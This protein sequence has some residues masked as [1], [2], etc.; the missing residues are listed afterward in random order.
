MAKYRFVYANFWSDDRVMDMAAAEKLCFLY[1][2]TNSQ[3]TQIGI[4]SLNIRKAAFDMGIPP[5]KVE[6]YFRRF[7]EN[8]L[9][10]FNRDTGEM[11]V[12][13]WGRYNFTRGGKPVED[14]V[15][16]ELSLVKDASL[17]SFVAAHIPPGRIRSLYDTWTERH[18]KQNGRKEKQNE[19][20]PEKTESRPAA[21]RFFERVFGT[22]APAVEQ[23]LLEWCS[24]LSEEL[25][26]EA[27]K[28]SCEADRP[29]AYAQSILT[30][31]QAE[32][33]STLQ[34]MRPK[35][36][37]AAEVPLYEPLVLDLTAGE[38]IG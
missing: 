7:E 19:T 22:P 26:I 17:V 20:E 33:K 14:C 8:G 23:G 12:R 6:Q 15:E 34:D 10:R 4:Y 32:G 18:Q 29:Y 21:V 2:L 35:P 36:E 1:V 28:L 3:T 13:H 30:S 11:A 25:V 27:L 5:K 24:S 37:K 31:W 16:K 9:I 38:G